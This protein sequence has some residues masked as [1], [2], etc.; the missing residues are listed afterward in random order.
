[1]GKR[2]TETIR[3]ACKM[4]SLS[5]RTMERMIQ[6]GDVKSTKIGKRRLIFVES[7]YAALG[8]GNGAE[9]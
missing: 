4:T 2:I 8:V 1:M 3:Q 7:I 6:R 9:E 5:T